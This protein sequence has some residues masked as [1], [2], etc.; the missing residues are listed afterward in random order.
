MN[1]L[2][3]LAVGAHGGLGRWNRLTRLTA[4]ASI[5]GTLAIEAHGRTS[6]AGLRRGTPARAMCHDAPVGLEQAPRQHRDGSR[7]R[8]RTVV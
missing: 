2:L 1:D 4:T 3:A 7:V 6:N 5:T 8:P